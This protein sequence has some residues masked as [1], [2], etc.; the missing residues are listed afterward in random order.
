VRCG[1]C[2]Q[3]FNALVSLQEEIPP[4]SDRTSTTSINEVLVISAGDADSA[5]TGRFQA[6]AALAASASDD[7]RAYAPPD[8][9][10]PVERDFG[11]DT[12]T[13]RDIAELMAACATPDTRTPEPELDLGVELDI[14]LQMAGP[15]ARATDPQEEPAPQEPG[16]GIAMPAPAEP[17]ATVESAE[18]RASEAPPEDALGAPLEASPDGAPNDAPNESVPESLPAPAFHPVDIIEADPVNHFELTRAAN[19]PGSGLPPVANDPIVDESEWTV[20]PQLAAATQAAMRPGDTTGDGDDDDER[21]RSGL[22]WLEIEAAPSPAISAAVV[23]AAAATRDAADVADTQHQDAMLAS[24]GA[25]PAPAQDPRTRQFMLAGAVLLGILLLAQVVH[26]NRRE[27][28]DSVVLHAPL[29]ALYGAI[30]RPI[31]PDWDLAAYDVRQLGVVAEP[32][33]AGTLTVRA[34]IRN[35]GA[36]AQP[37]PLLRVTLQDRYGNRIAMRDL[38]P[39]EY[40]GKDGR[41]GPPAVRAPMLAPGRRIDVQVGLLDP[42][43]SAVGFEL[44][45]CLRREDGRTACANDAAAAIR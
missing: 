30:G 29:T 25:K 5:N 19:D 10:E 17:V 33:A 16:A 24:L 4:A 32:V 44:D 13:S 45:A 31:V 22:R 2:A 36:R 28:A 27:L 39:S 35:Q 6:P 15:D 40:A 26:R 8:D 38:K 3:V 14:G 21:E 41:P 18:D 9:D 37:A 43:G 7:G 12:L 11:A 1:R 20:V 23:A 42:G 34:S